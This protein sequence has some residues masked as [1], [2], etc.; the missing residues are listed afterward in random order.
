MGMYPLLMGKL[1]FSSPILMIGSSLGKASTS[2]SS[3]PFRTPHIEDPGTLPSPST[4]SEFSIPAEMGMLLSTTMV[5]YEANIDSVVESSPS[6]FQ[7]KEEDPYAFPAWAM[8]SYHSH[9]CLDDIFPSDE[10]IVKVISTLEQSWGYF[11]HRYYFLPKLDDIELD[12]FKEIFSEKIGRL[13]V[14]L[15]SPRKYVEGNMANLSPTLPI[16][17]SC[18]LGKIENMYIGANFSPDDIREYTE[19]F[20]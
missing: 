18:V 17:I 11:H 14:S 4:S 1:N 16:N 19:V 6:S 9:D 12:E 7:M 10:A 2:L 3:V 20:K 13:V 8:S 15:G 5:A